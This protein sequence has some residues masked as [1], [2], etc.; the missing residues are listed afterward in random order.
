MLYNL[1]DSIRNDLSANEKTSLLK[2]NYTQGV[3]KS[4]KEKMANS[5]H[6]LKLNHDSYLAA[7]RLIADILALL[8][9]YSIRTL[10]TRFCEQPFYTSTERP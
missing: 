2:V 8:F 10:S 4:R 1:S 7:I 6:R 9:D 5:S 3:E